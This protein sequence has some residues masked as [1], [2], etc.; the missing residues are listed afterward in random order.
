M[1]ANRTACWI[2]SA[3]VTL[4][5]AA[6]IVAEESPAPRLS[7]ENTQIDVGKVVRGDTVEVAFE[8]G[9]QGDSELR[10]L[11]AKPG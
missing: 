6:P 2:L 9:N 4:G 5:L 8:L 3:A 1:I 7:V 10:I 11:S